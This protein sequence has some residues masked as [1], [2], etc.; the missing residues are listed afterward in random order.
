MNLKAPLINLVTVKMKYDP[1]A[2]KLDDLER[3][4]LCFHNNK[5]YV[6]LCLCLWTAQISN[7]T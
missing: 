6:L 5:A 1:T 4:I 7:K 2:N 3:Q